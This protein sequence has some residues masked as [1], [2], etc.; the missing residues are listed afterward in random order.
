MFKNIIALMIIFCSVAY[1]DGNRPHVLLQANSAP[2]FW[3][4]KLP[5]NGLGGEIIHEISKVEGIDTTIVFKP[6]SRLI[7]DDS[8]NDLGDPAF[9]MRN[10]EY[11]EI[12]PIMAYD[13]AF[14]YYEKHHTYEHEHDSIRDLKSLADLKGKRIGIL[15]GSVI[16]SKHLKRLGITFEQS[17]NQESLFKKLRIGRLD[18]VLEIKLVGNRIID[19]L[20]PSDGGDFVVVPIKGESNPI[21]IMLAY[22]QE[23]ASILASKYRHGLQTIIQNGTYRKIFEKYA[24]SDIM[25]EALLEKLKMYN[26]LYLSEDE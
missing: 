13:I 24:G 1:T 7:E 20:F 4:E 16:D 22:E 12:V 9:F 2:P 6:L 17:Y 15:K 14:Y 19:K 10:Q 25:F 3:S 18:Y 23:D 11:K 5:F 8:N 21:A 26:L